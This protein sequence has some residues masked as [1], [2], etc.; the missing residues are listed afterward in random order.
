[1]NGNV[2]SN[3]IFT[4]FFTVGLGVEK[5]EKAFKNEGGSIP[6]PLY[7]GLL[8]KGNGHQFLQVPPLSYLLTFPLSHLIL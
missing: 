8:H 3:F 2:V 7:Y 1:V 6:Q 5:D 4:P